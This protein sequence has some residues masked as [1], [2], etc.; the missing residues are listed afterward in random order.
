[1]YYPDYCH[2]YDNG[3]DSGAVHSDSVSGW[4]NLVCFLPKVGNHDLCCT[5]SRQCVGGCY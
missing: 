1:M 4:G 2:H 5:D 3:G